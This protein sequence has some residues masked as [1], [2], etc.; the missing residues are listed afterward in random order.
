MTLS[1]LR[2]PSAARRS[3]LIAV[4]VSPLAATRRA[5]AS[6]ATYSTSR[7]APSRP[8]AQHNP[9]SVSAASSWP[10]VANSSARQR[11]MI[12]SAKQSGCAAIRFAASSSAATVAGWMPA[13][14]IAPVAGTVS[15][16][17][18]PSWP[19]AVRASSIA[20]KPC[21]SCW[22]RSPDR[23]AAM[24]SRPC[25][26]AASAGSAWPDRTR[27][28]SISATI[29]SASPACQARTASRLRPQT[30]SCGSPA[31]RAQAMPSP[32]S[33]AARRKSPRWN[34]DQAAPSST[35]TWM[36]GSAA[37]GMSAAVVRNWPASLYR[38]VAIHHRASRAASSRPPSGSA[39]PSAHDNAARMLSC[40]ADR[41]LAH[42]AQPV[43][44]KVAS[45]DRVTSRA[46]SSSRRCTAV[47]SPEA[48]SR[49]AAN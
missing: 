27:L 2:P 39:P 30:S 16:R 18:S 40:P 31:C 5:S 6:G 9:T 29:R 12:V 25:A 23:K 3:A 26:R 46:Q 21:R 14:A 47:S 15:A 34:A 24:A 20:S 44:P 11:R 7:T 48:A 45:A 38:P 35:R 10:K 42:A 28:A 49:P 32:T 13:P 36:P 17:A 4:A 19:A 37:A 33:G 1:T 8:A 43:L 22:A 41:R